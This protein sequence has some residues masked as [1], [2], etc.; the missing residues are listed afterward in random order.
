[1]Q[2]MNRP[3]EEQK[4]LLGEHE[5]L[6]IRFHSSVGFAYLVMSKNMSVAL[7]RPGLPKVA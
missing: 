3:G 2:R 6:V 4:G 5:D 7:I 1:M